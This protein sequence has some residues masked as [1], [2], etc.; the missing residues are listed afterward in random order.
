MSVSPSYRAARQTSAFV[1]LSKRGRIVVG[2]DDRVS[3]LQGLLTND[4]AALKPGN[5]C[6]AAYL[7]PQGRMITDMRVLNLGG[8]L[9][10]DVPPATSEM[11]VGRFREFI[12]M[13]DVAVENRTAACATFC[14][15]G[16]EAARVVTRVLRFPVGDGLSPLGASE[17]GS[18][19]EYQ[20]SVGDFGGVPIVTARSN[21][22]GEVGFLLYFE[23][24]AREALGAA[25]VN[26]GVAEIDVEMFD[27]LRVEAGRPA[28]PTDMDQKTIPL[29]AGIE[30][31][32]ISMTKGCYVGQ[33]VIVRILHRGRGRVGRLLVGISFAADYDPP[34]RGTMLTVHDGEQ[35]VGSITSSVLSPALG[36]PIALGYVERELSEP[37]TEL[38]AVAGLR[39]LSGVVTSRPFLPLRTNKP[40]R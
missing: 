29:E 36:R 12:I 30:D 28:F 16:P 34:P 7:T 37:G 4:I 19:S 3:Y 10:L 22:T 25:L 1:D 18:Y 21:E 27:I 31:R 17:L 35:T 11:L 5:G 23:S 32:A 8:E 2:G 15:C 20:H 14:I 33:E 40:L 24:A 9:L 26:T 39:R 13:E 6:Y 38:I